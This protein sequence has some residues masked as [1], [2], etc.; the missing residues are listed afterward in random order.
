MD[1]FARH[2]SRS[3][4]P[5]SREG[6]ALATTMMLLAILSMLGAAAIQSTTLEVQISARDRDARTAAYVAEAGLEE[7]RYYVAR[8]WGKLGAATAAAP[9]A[10]EVPALT[11]ILPAVPW[12]SVSC[13][14]TGF[15]LYDASATAYAVQDCSGPRGAARFRL[16]AAAGTPAAGRFF[17]VREIPAAT[18]SG[19]DLEVTDPAW[20]VVSPPGTWD[21]WVV[22]DADDRAYRVVTSDRN[23]VAGT[24]ILRLDAAPGSGPYRMGRHPWIASLAAGTAPPGD[25]DSSS[26]DTWD[27][28]FPVSGGTG[29]ASVRAEAG[30][31]GEYRVV[32]PSLVGRSRGLAQMVV[33][34]TG[35]PEQAV[36]S[37]RVGHED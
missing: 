34:R 10:V 23:S 12:D 29:R 31:P 13:L 26:A 22:W 5:S 3:S 19:T 2:R 20:A 4:P 18:V 15:T 27:R 28:D 16:A 37:W 30:G 14:Y 24:V 32:S 1:P 25:A 36:T 6:F 17:L 8:G 21:G 35:L 7:A 11:P 33:R 9:G